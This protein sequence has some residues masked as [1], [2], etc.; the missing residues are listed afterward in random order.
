MRRIFDIGCSFLPGINMVF[1]SICACHPC[2][3]A[4]L[5]VSASFQFYRMIPEGN[6]ARCVS[7]RNVSSGHS[8]TAKADSTLRASQP[9]P[10]ASTRRALHRLTSEVEREPEHSVGYG[11]QRLC[12]IQL[13]LRKA[14]LAAASTCLIRGNRMIEPQQGL[15]QPDLA[16]T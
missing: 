8:S 13:C 10:Q 4:M 6:P 12:G 1:F 11:R 7:G 16:T 14:A 9:V 3:G 5:I 2:A 15:L